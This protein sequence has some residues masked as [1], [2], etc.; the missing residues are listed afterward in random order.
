[1]HTAWMK[2]ALLQTILWSQPYVR[3][4]QI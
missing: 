4:G 3:D 2:A 1:M